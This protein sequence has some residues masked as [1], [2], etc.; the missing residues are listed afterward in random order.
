MPRKD[1]AADALAK[2][3]AVRAIN[4]RAALL[5][6]VTL[7][8]RDRSAYVVARAATLTGERGVRDAIPVLIDR[9]RHFLTDPKAADPNCDAVLS[10][11]QAL[12]TLEAGYEAED[13]AL[14]AVR[15][16]RF[17]AVFGGSTDTAVSARGRASILLAAMGSTHAVRC[18]VQLLAAPDARPPREV[19]NW[20]AR[21]DAARALTMIG[22]DAAA[23]VLRFKLMTGDDEPNVLSDCLA[24][25]LVI[26][27]DDALPLARQMLAAPRTV[28]AAL[29]AI[30]GWRDAR[31]VSLLL[32]AAD[33]LLATDSRDLYLASLAMTRQPPAVDFLLDLARTSPPALATAALTALDPLR[34]L[35]GV[36]KRIDDAQRKR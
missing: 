5:A 25:L 16:V 7:A 14:L 13:V 21:A 10:L 22:N 23:A 3:A 15:H 31:A 17:E 9:L 35:P 28:E 36:A 29:L 19:V 27:R 1:P 18:A 12:V 8:L 11:L 6:G 32:D 33:D 30:G 24:G 34:L 4:D 20:P 2:L 26:E